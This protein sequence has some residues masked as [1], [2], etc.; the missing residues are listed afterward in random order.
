MSCCASNVQA[1]E[2]GGSSLVFEDDSYEPVWEHEQR[3]A[4]QPLDF[5]SA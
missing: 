3:V 1:E 5:D 2:M 4:S